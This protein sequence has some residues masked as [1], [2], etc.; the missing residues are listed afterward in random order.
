MRSF[1]DYTFIK[2]DIHVSTRVFLPV[3]E[4][5]SVEVDGER[6]NSDAK[7]GI[8]ARIYTDFT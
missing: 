7:A 1:I 5:K 3:M 6:R 4:K 2:E 8:N